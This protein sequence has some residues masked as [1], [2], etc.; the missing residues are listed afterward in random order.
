M[1]NFNDA[2]QGL[3]F[4]VKQQAYIE[5]QVWETR[6]PE[7]TYQ[8]F[9]PVDRAA[10]PWTRT[11]TFY[12]TDFAGRPKWIAGG[13]DDIPL[14]GV[15]RT[16]YESEVHMAAIGYDYSIDE[17]GT[18]R[19]AGIQLD[20]DRARAA[21]RSYEL[22][23]DDVA[24]IGDTTKALKGLLNATTP[25]RADVADGA[26]TNPE[27]STK[28]ADE[29]LLDV[30]N[31]ITGIWVTTKQIGMADTVLLPPDQYSLIATK[32]LSDTSDRTI[33]DWIEQNNIYTKITGQKLMI[34]ANR[35]LA[36]LGSGST[37]RMVVYRRSPEVV[38]MHMP[39]PLQFLQAQQIMLRF[40]VPGIFRIGGVDVRLP[41][42]VRY[43]DGI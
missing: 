37:D 14:V 29:I 13:A 24:Y 26:S 20:A 25:G 43:Y 10:P 9:V 16:K 17:I 1:L 11:I 21:R 40:V 18:A 35:R 8:D 42:E 6:Y 4:L 38:K 3:E 27:W 30:N 34:R 23:M 32:R 15:N 22:Y 31:A 12:S 36:G 33:L 39:M 28:T 5:P 2:Q 41:E 19:Q 7:V